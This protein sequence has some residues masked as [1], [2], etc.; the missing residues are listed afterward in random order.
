[1][2]NE[3]EL[4]AADTTWNPDWFAEVDNEAAIAVLDTLGPDSVEADP[5]TV[6]LDAFNKDD[7]QTFP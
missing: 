2:P 7:K 5:V 4:A 6:A 1:M 3:N